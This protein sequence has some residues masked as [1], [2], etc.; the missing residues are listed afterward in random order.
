MPDNRYSYEDILHKPRPISSRHAHMPNRKRAAQFMPFAALQG[1][2]EL[3]A[4]VT[5]HTDTPQV[6]SEDA[7][8]ALNKTIQTVLEHPQYEVFIK[9]YDSQV[10]QYVSECDRIRYVQRENNVLVLQNGKQ[11]MISSIIQLEILSE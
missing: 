7:L 9:Y 10:C 3:L 6:L 4:T 5:Q 8:E 1:Y 11:I 2:E